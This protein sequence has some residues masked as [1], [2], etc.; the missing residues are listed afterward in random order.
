MVNNGITYYGDIFKYHGDIVKLSW[1]YCQIPYHG[2]M[3]KS[4]ARHML[5]IFAVSG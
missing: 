1:R 2:D 4:K 5:Q 3:V